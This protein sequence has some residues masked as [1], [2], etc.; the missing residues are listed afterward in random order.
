MI[1]F[2]E[3]RAQKFLAD[4]SI[5][6]FSIDESVQRETGNVACRRLDR[7]GKFTDLILPSHKEPVNDIRSED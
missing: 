5:D 2:D 3:I 6:S 4:K 1:K 7:D